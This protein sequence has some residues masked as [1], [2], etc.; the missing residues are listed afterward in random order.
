MFGPNYLKAFFCLSLVVVFL[1]P[2]YIYFYLSPKFTDLIIENSEREAEEVTNHLISMF[3]SGSQELTKDLA[4]QELPQQDKK[5]QAQFHI[6]KIKIFLANGEVI[7]SSDEKDIGVMNTNR[8][9]TEIVAQGKLYSKVVEK[10]KET[11]EGRRV[12]VDVVEIY[13]PIMKNGSFVGAFEIYYNISDIKARLNKLMSKV[14]IVFFI[15][16]FILLF[17]IFAL[18]YRAGKSISQRKRLREE[19][20]RNYET[21]IIFNNLLKLSLV[22]TSLDELLEIFINNITSLPWLEVEPVGAL[23]L[24]DDE[25]DEL[26]L[27]AQR[28]LPKE[29]LSS[30]ASVPL[31]KCICGRT[32]AS[33]LEYFSDC[34]DDDH[35]ITYGGMAPHGHYSV[36]ISSSTGKVIGVFTLYTKVGIEHNPRAEEIFVAASKLIAGIIERKQLEE[37]L[38]GIS[39]SDELTGLLNRRGF[40]TLAQKQLELANRNRSRMTMFYIDVDNLKTVNDQYGHS[41]GDQIIIDMANILKKTF[42]SSDVIARMGGDEFVVFGMSDSESESDLVLSKRLQENIEIFNKKTARLYR[43]SCSVG[44]AYYDPQSPESLDEILSRADTVMYEEKLEK[45]EHQDYFRR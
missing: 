19:Q 2:T 23:F 40:T 35:D 9:F 37:K 33:G 11:L 7:Y 24:L 3:F 22:R 42:R 12:R 36:P 25:S 18:Y 45:K 17:A 32:A 13:V 34:V 5:L 43:L 8:Y 28:G 38:H 6:E 27:K 31:G 15:I 41:V 10:E 29:L 4:Q 14:Y 21:E 26:K 44:E 1:L 39:I 30:C 16:L 20:K